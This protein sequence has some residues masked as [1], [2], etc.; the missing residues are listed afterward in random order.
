[1]DDYNS[2]EI[3]WSKKY[4][5]FYKSITVHDHEGASHDPEEHLSCYV[6]TRI[7]KIILDHD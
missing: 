1:M 4:E 6:R 2:K 7:I 3:N 5:A